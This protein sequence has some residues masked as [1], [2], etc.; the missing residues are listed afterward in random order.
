MFAADNGKK[1]KN[2][3]ESQTA[4][5]NQAQDHTLSEQ[6]PSRCR[7]HSNKTRQREKKNVFD[8]GVNTQETL[9]VVLG[10]V[11]AMFD[12]EI[13]DMMRKISSH[14]LAP[15]IEL[16][17]KGAQCIRTTKQELEALSC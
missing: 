4:D 1:G 13:P 5:L 7:I 10:Q 14:Y 8:L 3:H 2:G 9:S 11:K 17:E 15:Q 6:R 16:Q 12:Q